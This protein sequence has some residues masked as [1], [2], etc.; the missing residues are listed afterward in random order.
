MRKFIGILLTAAVAGALLSCSDPFESFSDDLETTLAMNGVSSASAEG[1][2]AGGDSESGTSSASY[3]TDSLVS[4]A[5]N[6]YHVLDLVI[7]DFPVTHPDFENFQEQAYD[8]SPWGDWSYSGYNDNSTWLE[9][10]ADYATYG[11]GNVTTPDYGAQIGT[12]GYPMDASLFTN[13]PDYLQSKSSEGKALQYGRFTCS[14]VHYSGF[15]SDLI[16]SGSCSYVSANGD[17]YDYVYVTPNMV[18]PYLTF[19]ASL[20]D[21]MMHEPIITR[22]RYACDNVYFEQWYS[23]DNDVAL[24][25]NTI[26]ELLLEGSAYEV[27]HTWNDGGYFPLDVVDGDG[28][29]TGASS[30]NQYGPQSLSIFCPPYDY[31][32]A[33]SQEDRDGNST[34][35]LCLMWLL[36]GGPR[37]DTA[38]ATA[39]TYYANQGDDIGTTHLRNAGFTIMGYAAF[40]YAEGAGETFE[41]VGDDDIWIYVDGVLVVDLGG[42]HLAAY[43]KVDMDYLAENAHGC[44][45]GEPLAGETYSGAN[46]DLD[47]DGT[48]KDGTWHHLHLFYAER[49]TDASNL[50]ISTTISEFSVNQYSE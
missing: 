30:S 35:G 29:R 23:D 20:G 10:R 18:S 26:L 19:D 8:K 3:S 21:D 38:A 36:Y 14:G 27:E 6:S 13:L 47:E 33:S 39:A 48:W 5:G 28:L 16:S 11:C 42:T 24:R 31:A 49:Q 40:K 45:E 9:R 46:C 44:H 4:D 25:T 1:D 41:I 50:K 7:R 17:W 32:Y 43:G 12:D 15:Y 22:S 37:V 2:S 34:Y